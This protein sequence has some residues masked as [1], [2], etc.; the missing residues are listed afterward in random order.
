MKS[1]NQDRRWRLDK[2]PGLK[3][4]FGKFLVQYTEQHD[5]WSPEQIAE[6]FIATHPRLLEEYAEAF[7]ADL[8]RQRAL[9]PATERRP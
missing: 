5:G 4:R 1:D 8:V 6:A 3:E 2:N 9:W 7:V